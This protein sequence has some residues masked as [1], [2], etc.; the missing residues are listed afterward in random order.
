LNG[1]TRECVQVRGFLV[2]PGLLDHPAVRPHYL[3]WRAAVELEREANRNM[4]G[5]GALVRPETLAYKQRLDEAV[6]KVNQ[7][8]VEAD[9]LTA[10]LG[11][12]PVAA[13]LNTSSVQQAVPPP[14]GR[15]TAFVDLAADRMTVIVSDREFHVPNTVKRRNPLPAILFSAAV[16]IG[17]MFTLW[18]Y[19][20][21]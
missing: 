12:V 5:A 14:P 13:R 20:H 8:Q 11:V 2:D 9:S 19:L 6:L 21:H 17:V 18:P 1:T 10:P 16:G 3:K 15:S 4:P 7:G